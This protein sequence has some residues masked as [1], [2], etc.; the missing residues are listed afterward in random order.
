MLR[1]TDDAAAWDFEGGRAGVYVEGDRVV[2]VS[3]GR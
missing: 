1:E 3:A 2:A